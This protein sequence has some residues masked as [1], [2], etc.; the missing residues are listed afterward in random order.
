MCVHS[1]DRGDPWQYVRYCVWSMESV[2]W[3][4]MVRL[5]EA[6]VGKEDILLLW[7]QVFN[8]PRIYLLLH[9]LFFIF[10]P[11]L[12]NWIS[13]SSHKWLNISCLISEPRAPSI[14]K[15]ALYIHMWRTVA[16]NQVWNWSLRWNSKKVLME[17]E[18]CV[19]EWE[20][21]SWI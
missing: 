10:T 1:I 11:F 19:S 16:E 4:R 18:W 5:S 12:C 2:R 8:Q 21:M 17:W 6:K 13:T 15:R 3:G 9:F 7:F 14:L 20:W